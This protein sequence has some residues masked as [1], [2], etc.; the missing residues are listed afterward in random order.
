MASKAAPP[1]LDGPALTAD[2]VVVDL[3]GDAPSYFSHAKEFSP[4]SKMKQHLK[5]DFRM[6]QALHVAHGACEAE[7][8]LASGAGPVSL[9]ATGV[10]HGMVPPS[11][12][13]KSS[14]AAR[15]KLFHGKKRAPESPSLGA[16]AAVDAS[17]V[18]QVDSFSLEP[19]CVAP[20]GVVTD[21]KGGAA[22]PSPMNA[23]K[24]EHLK[25]FHRKMS[26]R[27][28]GELQSKDEIISVDPAG[29]VM[30][31]V[32]V[33][34]TPLIEPVEPAPELSPMMCP[35]PEPAAELSP[36]LAPRSAPS[37]LCV[38]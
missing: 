22:P 26:R 35:W 30:A 10:A 4:S 9:D 34:K 13:E 16:K 6:N 17:G 20:D 25:L 28:T 38:I 24:A 15:L 2:G 14:T 19:L 18:V 23:G 37:P 27:H 29:K 12:D 7:A 21:S 3:D 36:A 11:P 1:T 32:Q 5:E 31:T 33:D 8:R